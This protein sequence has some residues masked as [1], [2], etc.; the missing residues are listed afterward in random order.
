MESSEID[1]PTTTAD[2]PSSPNPRASPQTNDHDI[3]NTACMSCR[4]RHLKCDRMPVCTRCST[5][6]T[7]CTYSKSRRGHRAR[8]FHSKQTSSTNSP[9]K[10]IVGDSKPKNLDVLGIA[11]VP[12][13]EDEPFSSL[14]EFPLATAN[15]NLDD[16][17]TRRSYPNYHEQCID[18][19]FQYFYHAHPFLPPRHQ[20][21]QILQT[22]PVNHLQTA[23]YYV[24]SRYVYGQS[25]SSFALEFESY[26]RPESAGP[27]DASMVQAM[28]LFALG[29]DTDNNQARAVEVLI[30]AQSLAMELGMN[31]REY[32]ILNGRGSALCEESLRRTWWELYVVS[33]LVAG[34]HG[35][36]IFYSRSLVSTVPVPCEATEF[37]SGIIPRLYTIEEFEDNLFQR[38][39]IDWSSY[40]YRIAAA[41]N[42][43]RIL[44]SNQIVCIDDAEL[45]G[46]EA[47]ITNWH[48][49]L[50]PNKRNIIDPFGN[51]DEMLFQAQMISYASSILLHRRFSA[52]QSLAVQTITTCTGRQPRVGTP[53]RS[54]LDN[55]H[56]AKEAQAASNIGKLIMLPG[57]LIKHTH[58]FVCALTL[59]SISH[60]SLWSSLPVIGPDQDLQQQIQLS[61]GALK[62]VAHVYPSARMGYQQVSLVAQKIYANRKEEAI[63]QIFWQDFADE[64]FMTDLAK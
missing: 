52:L 11:S 17:Y 47:Y 57:S 8:G 32:A 31:Q 28:L 10:A 43:E 29:L 4:S 1:T 14:L 58:F 21:L 26:L 39:E 48:L 22:N 9:I 63:G 46:L 37:A 41:R 25:Q 51:L 45:Y 42:L 19:F 61:A 2:S 56:T 50:P 55:V 35:K 49:H 36:D 60:L 62:A 59:S 33:I 30:K 44:Q 53:P 12:V 13:V 3:A 7:P 20:L 15:P 27:K 16:L 40:A 5:Q 23:M 18:G 54:T 24:G 34:F 6:G 64:D 38:E